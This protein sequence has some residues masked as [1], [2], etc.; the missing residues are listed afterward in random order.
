MENIT[1]PVALPHNQYNLHQSEIE[2]LQDC[3]AS[4]PQGIGEKNQVEPLLTPI[5][6]VEDIAQY[7]IGNYKLGKSLRSDFSRASAKNLNSTYNR[8]IFIR[9]VILD[10][11]NFLFEKAQSDFNQ[12]K[13]YFDLYFKNYYSKEAPMEMSL[14]LDQY[15]DAALETHRALVSTL[16]NLH[17]INININGLIALQNSISMEM[18]D[19]DQALAKRSIEKLQNPASNTRIKRRKVWPNG[20]NFAL[21]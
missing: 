16:S 4:T 15:F 8:A 1:G 14:Y 19:N 11:L 17:N 12:Y 9:C 10:D 21:V 7:A 5:T 2:Y 6:T 13:F 20:L 3:L 18:S